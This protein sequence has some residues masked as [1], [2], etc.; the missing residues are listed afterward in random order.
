M[1]QINS[2]RERRQREEGKRRRRAR[3]QTWKKEISGIAVRS[4]E[5]LH[6]V[7]CNPQPYTVLKTTATSPQAAISGSSPPHHCNLIQ[8]LWHF[9]HVLQ[10][11][12][13]L[14]LSIRHLLVLVELMQ[15]NRLTYAHPLIRKSE[16]HLSEE[17]LCA[18]ENSSEVFLRC[19]KIH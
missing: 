5:C 6:F 15:Y 19:H 18:N 12:L 8:T 16:Y 3:V 13:L 9:V 11:D 4:E 1:V 10:L 17:L 7:P 2:C 14:A